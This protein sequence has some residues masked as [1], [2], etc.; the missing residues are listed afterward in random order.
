M[1]FNGVTVPAPFGDVTVTCVTPDCG[2]G[3]LSPTLQAS[4]P[5]SV[6][7]IARRN[8]L[9]PTGAKLIAARPTDATP[10]QEGDVTLRAVTIT[11][12]A[13]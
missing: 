8:G 6:T 10:S 5:Q 7:L 11:I 3:R 13:R 2:N 12:P 1:T 9:P 4:E